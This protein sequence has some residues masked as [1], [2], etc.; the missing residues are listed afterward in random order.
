[1]LPD[2]FGRWL[3]SV[4]ATQSDLGPSPNLG[5]GPDSALAGPDDHTRLVEAITDGVIPAEE[6]I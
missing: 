4:P 5:G 1:M 6:G 2:P 3:L